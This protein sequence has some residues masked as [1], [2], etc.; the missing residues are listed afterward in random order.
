MTSLSP[1]EVTPKRLACDV[2]LVTEKKE[3]VGPDHFRSLI[4]AVAALLDSSGEVINLCEERFRFLVV[5]AAAMLRGRTTLLPPSRAPASIAELRAAYPGCEVV[6]DAFCIPAAGTPWHGDVQSNDFTAAIGHTS[7]S[8]GRPSPHPKPFSGFCA[9]T[10]L[11]AGTI[12]AALAERG[13]PERPWIVAT[14]PPQHMYGLE[15]SV[16]LPLLAGFGI[17]CGRPLLPADVAVALT[18]VPQPRVL[19]STPVHLRALAESAVDYPQTAVVLSAT[20]PLQREL[21]AHI[22]GRTGATVIEMFGSTETCVVATRRTAHE[23]GW[24]AYP[25]IRLEPVD[26]GTIVSAP[27]LTR[28]QLLHDLIE[29]RPDRSFTIIG[30]GGDTIEVA[31]KRASLADLTRRLLALPGV[32]DAVVFQPPGNAG[33]KANRCAAL[34]VAPGMSASEVTRMFRR[35][36]DAAFIPR[37]LVAVARLPRNEVGKL[38]LD[39][40]ITAVSRPRRGR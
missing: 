28:E 31:G 24:R 33:G 26:R 27:W 7:G 37:P 6:D 25:G 4:P 39:E 8:T 20:A 9:T 17:H 35:Q 14:V 16:L 1:R 22:E 36:V 38:P 12:R 2:A 21:A 11:N 3:A 15:T 10:A 18:E 32:E 23:E 13:A 19:V 5:F 29:M 40:L 34:V 30:R